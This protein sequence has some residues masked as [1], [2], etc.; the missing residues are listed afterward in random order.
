MT[1][2]QNQSA[3]VEETREAVETTPQPENNDKKKAGNK[4]S[5]ALSAIAIAIAIAAGIGL[6]GLNKQ[7]ATRQNATTSELSGQ[8]A[9]LQKAQESQKSELEGIIKQQADQLSQAKHEQE[10]LTKQL[11]ELQQKVAVISGSD[12]KTW[13][14]AQAD[15]LVKLA[16]RKLWSDQDVTTA[17]ALLKS[18]DASL[19][20]MN[21]PSLI[22]ARRAITD[23]IAT[24]S[25]VSQVDYDGMILKV[26]QLAN[27]IDNLRLAD[28][29]DDDSPMD[30]DSDELSS[31][32]SEWRVNLQKS[33]QNFMDSF[34]T[35]RRRDETA[36]PLLAPNQDIYLRENIRSRLLVAAQAVP[37]HQEETWKQS[38]D[39]VSTWVRAY[40]DTDDATTKAFLDEVDK[41]SQQSITMTVPETLQSQALLEKLMQTR[42]RNLMAQPAVT[43]GGAPSPAPAAPAAPAAPQG[44]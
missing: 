37:R 33:W 8:L 23:D 42:V 24:L 4:T 36:V 16:G 21:D 31:S 9:A 5:L 39:N 22:G 38:L 27:Q 40:Y 20:D 30:S 43:A 1:E 25:A 6:Y 13:L 29:N 7:Q 19:A 44:E 34:I 32:I 17:A 18:A 14:L 10:T 41:L 35:V 11:D 28:N 12:A 2:Q 3:V 15:F 26:N